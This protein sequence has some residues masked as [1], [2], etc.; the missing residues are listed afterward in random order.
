MKKQFI[1]REETLDKTHYRIIIGLMIF[2]VAYYYFLEPKT[3]GHDIRYTIYIFALPTLIGMIVLG[4][5]RR[6]FLLNRFATNRGFLLWTFMFFFY[7]L[8][9]LFFSYLSFG[10]LSKITWDYYNYKTS[11]QNSVETIVCPVT[12]FSTARRSHIDFKFN[13]RYESFRVR[14]SAIK[15]YENK[16]A[17][18]YNIKIS[19]TKGLWNYY[20]VN[21]WEVEPK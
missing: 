2:A 16:N 7:L 4:I 1:Q 13:N 21:D 5:Y 12:K 6:Q 20:I 18:E 17:K 11:Q 14:Y 3:I 15:D 10:Q 9:G 8:Q 19:A